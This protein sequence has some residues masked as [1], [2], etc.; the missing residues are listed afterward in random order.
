MGKAVVAVYTQIGFRART[1]VPDPAAL[2]TAFS[3]GDASLNSDFTWDVDTLIR[4]RFI[5]SQSELTANNNMATEFALQ[6]NRNATTWE[7]IGA[8]GGGTEAVDYANSN[9]T[10]GDNCTQLLSSPFPYIS[11]DGMEIT[12]T[13]TITFTETPLATEATEIE[14]SI[15]INSGV[16][17]DADAIQLRLIFSL[18]DETPPATI[19]GGGY[20]EYPDIT[21]SAEA[22]PQ[23]IPLDAVTLASSPQELN[24]QAD[25]VIPMSEVTLVGSAETMESV[26]S[27]P[28]AQI[29]NMVAATLASAA[30]ALDVIPGNANVF[31]SDLTLASAAQALDVIPGSV[32]VLMGTATLVSSAQTL[33]VSLATYVALG[34]T[35]L[36]SSPQELEA[37][38]GAVA[39]EMQV[40]TLTSSPQV[41]GVSGAT[42]I[43]MG[44]VTL[45]SSTQSLIV[46]LAVIVNIQEITLT[47]AAQALSVGVDAGVV[48][49]PSYR[50]VGRGIMRGVGR[51]VG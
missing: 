16:V 10:D 17:S 30:Q 41:L 42:I 45:S 18:D 21:V 47:G 36:V 8:I 34:T 22:G 35:T 9:F 51:G 29:A 40:V 39:V 7:P 15:I 48:A 33:D 49:L 32:S 28:P 24:A 1:N 23:T 4:V 13:D 43:M 46:L 11:G 14:V 37:T 5:V 50:V 2:N 31:L 12:P 19:L 38:P 26:S 25:Q 3:A 27:Q 20:T 44:T 6:Y